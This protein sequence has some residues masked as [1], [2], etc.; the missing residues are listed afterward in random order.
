MDEISLVLHNDDNQRIFITC[1]RSLKQR[2]LK[3]RDA[4]EKKKNLTVYSLI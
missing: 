1:I 2:A 3:A 4:L